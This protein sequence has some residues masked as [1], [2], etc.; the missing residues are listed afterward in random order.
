M[1]TLMTTIEHASD[2]VP[3]NEGVDSHRK[4]EQ[5]LVGA[6]PFLPWGDQRADGRG[7]E[8]DE[9]RCKSREK[10]MKVGTPSEV[11]RSGHEQGEQ[12]AEHEH[13]RLRVVDAHIL[14]RYERDAAWFVGRS[15]RAYICLFARRCA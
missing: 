9:H 4:R 3:E 11:E 8:K 2:N 12:E 10:R 1:M 13:G 6:R 7:D 5:P 15:G 14:F